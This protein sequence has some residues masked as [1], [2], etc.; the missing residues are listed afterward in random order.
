M[1]QHARKD[2][3]FEIRMTAQ[4]KRLVAEAAKLKGMN[5]SE[6]ALKA[7]L[8]ASRKAISR[9][10]TI[11][12]SQRDQIAMADAL[13]DPPAPNAALRKAMARYR[14]MVVHD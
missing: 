14:K 6:F 8:A 9:I 13:L 12:L 5:P 3:R 1:T 11:K 10:Q 2:E 7:A 4:D